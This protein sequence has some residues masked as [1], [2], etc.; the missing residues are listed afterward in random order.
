VAF[1]CLF[2]PVRVGVGVHQRG[3]LAM[4]PIRRASAGPLTWAGPVEWIPPDRRYAATCV[5][6]DGA[7]YVVG[8]ITRWPRIEFE[9]FRS[10]RR[11]GSAVVGQL[12]GRRPSNAV[13]VFGRSRSARPGT[14]DASWT[15]VQAQTGRWSAI[16]SRVEK[17]NGRHAVRH[18]RR[19]L[20]APRAWYRQRRLRRRPRRSVPA[21][22]TSSLLT[23]QCKGVSEPV[24]VSPSRVPS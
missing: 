16:W 9:R 2:T 3:R 24:L 15:G 6:P 14:R 7:R 13:C 8:S 12:A 18:R 5:T 17:D 19:V 4:E 11:R 20:H 22:S 10:A 23:A 21:T 1:G